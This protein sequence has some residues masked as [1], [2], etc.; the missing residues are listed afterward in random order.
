MR[1][2]GEKIARVVGGLIR[3][4]ERMG[5]VEHFQDL[6]YGAGENAMIRHGDGHRSQLRTDGPVRI[7]IKNGK[8]LTKAA[9]VRRVANSA[10]PRHGQVLRGI[11]FVDFRLRL[12]INL[13][14]GIPFGKLGDGAQVAAPQAS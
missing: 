1:R 2:L 12:E 11:V 7:V 9:D 8:R 13:E 14:D 4:L 5:G 6:F 3:H 10:R